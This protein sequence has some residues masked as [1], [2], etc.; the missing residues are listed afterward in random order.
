MRCSGGRRSPGKRNR[1]RYTCTTSLYGVGR[2]LRKRCTI[3]FFC[4]SPQFG[5]SRPRAPKKKKILEK[6]MNCYVPPYEKSHGLG[7]RNNNSCKKKKMDDF[8]RFFWLRSPVIQKTFQTKS[9]T[10]IVRSTRRSMYPS[11]AR[12]KKDA[13]YYIR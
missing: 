9:A 10:S 6:K 3:F 1:K 5:S 4:G 7:V 8:R 12:C 13:C 2:V 11:M